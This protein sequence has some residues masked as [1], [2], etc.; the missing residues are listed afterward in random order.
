ML[1]GAGGCST[2]APPVRTASDFGA[3]TSPPVV[4]PGSLGSVFGA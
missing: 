2:A 1:A 3:D 4:E